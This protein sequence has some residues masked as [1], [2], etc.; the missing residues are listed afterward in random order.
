MQLSI[1]RRNEKR[2]SIN[3]RGRSPIDRV[4]TKPQVAVQDTVQTIYHGIVHARSVMNTSCRPLAVFGF[5]LHV[6]GDINDRWGP[7]KTR[8][9][10]RQS[11]V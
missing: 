10:T 11:G 5:P 2:V 6:V 1:S 3:A 8:K 4:N 9:D 7:K